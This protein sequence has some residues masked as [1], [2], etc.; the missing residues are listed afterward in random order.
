MLRI[1][2]APCRYK[3]NSLADQTPSLDE[4]NP[5]RQFQKHNFKRFKPG[6][7]FNPRE[8]TETDI[9][10]QCDKPGHFMRNCPGNMLTRGNG[11]VHRVRETEVPDLL[12]SSDSEDSTTA[13]EE[14]VPAIN[15][16]KN[17]R[18]TKKSKNQKYP[19]KTNRDRI[20]AAVLIHSEQIAS[21]TKQMSDLMAVL[22]SNPTRAEA[23]TA[24]IN[25]SVSQMIL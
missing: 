11:G 2:R 9:C 12:T 19:R 4:I 7:K 25:T 8:A 16:V 17:G 10:Y 18:F 14:N 13:G 24:R 23:N 6:G 5:F 21:L 1:P 3:V 20:N 22:A 15:Y